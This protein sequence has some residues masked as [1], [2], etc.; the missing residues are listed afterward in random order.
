MREITLLLHLI[1]MGLLTTTLVG[2]FFL[3]RQYKRAPDMKTKAVIVRSGRT[4]GLL[5]PVAM[6]ILLITGVGNMHGLGV[7]LLELGWL[8]A[9][10]MIFVFAFIAGIAL[11]VIARKRGALV[12]ALSLGENNPESEARL[13]SYDGLL[14]AGYFIMPILMLAIVYLSVI[15]RLGG[16]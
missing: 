15:G 5:S 12:Q 9:K 11:G 16:Q 10:L 6:L 3:H 7:G 2:G 8:S 4:F 13:K 1:G 14:S